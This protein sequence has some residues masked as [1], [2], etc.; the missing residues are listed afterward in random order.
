[1]TNDEQRKVKP[2][3]RNVWEGKRI[4][5][6]LSLDLSENQ[7]KALGADIRRQGGEVVELAISKSTSNVDRVREELERLEDAD[8]FVTRYRTGAAY[9]KV[10]FTNIEGLMALILHSNV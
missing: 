3:A 9:A 7:R 8:V 10:R 1:M 2:A 6:G 4:L 5:L